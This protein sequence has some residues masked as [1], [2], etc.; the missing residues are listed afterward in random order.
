MTDAKELAL[1]REH[2]RGTERR[3]LLPYRAALNDLAA[4]AA[5]GESERD[6]I[7]RWTETRRRIKADHG[8][9]H[10]QRIS[11][12]RS[13][14]PRVSGRTSSPESDSRQGARTSSIRAATSSLRSRTFAGVRSRGP[15]PRSSRSR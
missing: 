11:P 5:L 6:V 8:I 3:R 13:Y 2:P 9:D 4:Y 10:D 7:V 12:I 1:A 15:Q 14:R